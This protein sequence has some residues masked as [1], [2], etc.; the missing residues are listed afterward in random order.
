MPRT[1]DMAPGN[2]GSCGTD[3]RDLRLGDGWRPLLRSHGLVLGKAPFLFLFIIQIA[4]AYVIRA[5]QRFNHHCIIYI[6]STT[7]WFPFNPRPPLG[8]PVG[9]RLRSNYFS[10]SP[11]FATAPTRCTVAAAAAS[12][13]HRSDAASPHRTTLAATTCLPRTATATSSGPSWR[14]FST[15]YYR[16]QL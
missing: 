15:S 6:G 11:S 9:H 14:R 16:C 8:L 4:V 7:V 13:P 10:L 3:V 12:S 2:K 1:K 5:L